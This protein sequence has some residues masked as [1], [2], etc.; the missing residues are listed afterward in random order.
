MR[1][2]GV[3]SSNHVVEQGCSLTLFI[4]G[5]IPRIGNKLTSYQ[6]CSFQFFFYYIS[7][8]GNKLYSPLT[9]SLTHVLSIY[10]QDGEQ[11][12]LFLLGLLFSLY[13]SLREQAIFTTDLFPIFYLFLLFRWV[14]EQAMPPSTL[15]P[16]SCYSGS[17]IQLGVQV[18]TTQLVPYLHLF[19][20][21]FHTQGTWPGPFLNS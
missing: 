6:T 8:F 18:S 12:N 5:F 2:F 20:V 7:P 16:I 11:V 17:L 21:I 1:S 9:C 10:Q 14:R 19:R 4:L 15:F 13:F 3:D